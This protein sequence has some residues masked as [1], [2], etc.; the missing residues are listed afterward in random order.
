MNAPYATRS[1]D[2]AMRPLHVLIIG[3]GIGGLAHGQPLNTQSVCTPL[4]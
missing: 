2:V 3:G 4:K 1:F